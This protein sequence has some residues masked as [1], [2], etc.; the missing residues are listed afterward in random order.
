[1]EHRGAVLQF[2]ECLRDAREQEPYTAVR[3]APDREDD[4]HPMSFRKSSADAQKKYRD[5]HPAYQVTEAMRVKARYRAM[6]AL[7]RRYPKIYLRLYAAELE[8][9]KKE[10]K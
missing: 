9:I 6:A 10:G 3:G 4:Y 2:G 1:M 5:S 7:A 8:K